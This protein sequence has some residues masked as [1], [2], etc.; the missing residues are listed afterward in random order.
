MVNTDKESKLILT[1]YYDFGYIQIKKTLQERAYMKSFKISTGYSLGNT[2]SN[3]IL[4]SYQ[5]TTSNVFTFNQSLPVISFTYEIAASSRFSMSYSFS[6][7][8]SDIEMNRESFGSNKFI[9]FVKPCLTTF[10]KNR[11]EGYFQLKIGAIYDDKK[12]INIESN[13]IRYL[14]PANFKIYT[15]FT[16]LGINFNAS[17][18]IDV[19]FEWSL[20]SYETFSFGLKYN[21]CKNK[22]Y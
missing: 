14:I 5:D 8:K 20:W 13:T 6:Y 7:H 9:L 18:T 15:G 12:L 21:F 22:N 19:N 16:P 2:R 10:R 4:K 11:F 3:Y 17:K 1:E